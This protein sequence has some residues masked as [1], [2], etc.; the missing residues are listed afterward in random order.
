MSQSSVAIIFPLTVS[1]IPYIC[2]VHMKDPITDI[3]YVS[4][5]FYIVLF[6]V[7]PCL[8]EFDVYKCTVGS[9]P[10]TCV[11]YFVLKVELMIWSERGWASRIPGLSCPVGFVAY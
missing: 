5:T 8:G 4:I 2:N 7:F 11:V 3:L 6:I 9:V 1:H 10:L